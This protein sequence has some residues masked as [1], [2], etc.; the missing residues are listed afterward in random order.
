MPRLWGQAVG[1][2]L[3]PPIRHQERGTKALEQTHPLELR[4]KAEEFWTGLS[5]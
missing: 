5:L 1:T 4:R 2:N 3:S